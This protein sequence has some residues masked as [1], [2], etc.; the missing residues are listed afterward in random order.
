[1]KFLK[2]HFPFLFWLT[3]IFVQSSFPADVYPPIQI[4]SADKIVHIGVYGL[5]AALCYIS[6]IHQLNSPLLSKY[7]LLL[8]VLI[9]S[10][11]GVTDEIHQLFV[12]NR[13]CEFWDWLADFA[14]A[15]IMVLLIKYYLQKKYKIFKRKEI[16]SF[17]KMESLT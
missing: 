2:Y 7:P 12:P 3:A 8:T 17:Q 4:F 14:G 6:L 9:T 15:V 1:L 16:P 13:D 11:Y 10:L 5:L